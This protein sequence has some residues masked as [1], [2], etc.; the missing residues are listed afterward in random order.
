MNCDRTGVAGEKEIM[1]RS[2]LEVESTQGLTNQLLRE[3]R[4]TGSMEMSSSPSG[5]LGTLLV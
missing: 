5:A 2:I 3:K 4:R 1:L